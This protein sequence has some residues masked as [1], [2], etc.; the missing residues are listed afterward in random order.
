MSEIDEIIADLEAAVVKDVA[1]AAARLRSIARAPGPQARDERPDKGMTDL[2]TVTEAAKLAHRSKKTMNA[3]C[4]QH[5]ICGE[6]GL[7]VKI[8]K[9]W[10][11]SRSRLLRHLVEPFEP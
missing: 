1:V 7:A 6:A 3:W 5:P 10:L 8:G 9:R 2:I 11:V 4:R